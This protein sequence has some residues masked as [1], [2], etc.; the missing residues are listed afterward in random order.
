MLLLQEGSEQLLR[1]TAEAQRAGLDFG[2]VRDLRPLLDA[3]DRGGMLHPFL[4]HAV[5][6]TLDAAATLQQLV[7]QLAAVGP[8]ELKRSVVCQRSVRSVQRAVL[9]MARA[10]HCLSPNAC[11]RDAE[12]A[13]MC[14]ASAWAASAAAG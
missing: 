13:W 3:D 4:L 2:A 6:A 14:R 12:A 10:M 11:M 9:Q 1:E 5:A 8:G 7:E